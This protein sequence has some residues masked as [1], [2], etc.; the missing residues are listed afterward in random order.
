MPRGHPTLLVNACETQFAIRRERR[1]RLKRVDRDP[2]K[3]QCHLDRA[4]ISHRF[5][6]NGYKRLN[7]S[8]L[9]ISAKTDRLL[10]IVQQ[11]P[12]NDKR[13]RRCYRCHPLGHV[14]QYAPCADLA[15]PHLASLLELQDVAT[16]GSQTSVLARISQYAVESHGTPVGES[17]KTHPGT[18]RSTRYYLEGRSEVTMK[19]QVLQEKAPK[20]GQG[21]P[22]P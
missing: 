14:C 10:R 22:R 2:E 11:K 16:L 1:K 12:Q 13:A 7:Q 15:L 21:A 6:L 18:G 9:R 19:V 17:T 8:G 20:G 4:R 3:N 5:L